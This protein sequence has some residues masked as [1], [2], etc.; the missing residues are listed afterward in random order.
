M[1]AKTT[2]AEFDRHNDV[3]TIQ[4]DWMYTEGCGDDRDAGYG[5][6]ALDTFKRE[7][8]ELSAT[9][10]VG[11]KVVTDVG[12]GGGW[13]VVEITGK[14][15]QVRGFLLAEYLLGD[16]SELNGIARYVDDTEWQDWQ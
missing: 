6:D 1:D 11:A 10:P 2:P 13:P 12:P 15:R 14:R 7:L 9:Y 5:H 4:V 16:V 8:A 3:V